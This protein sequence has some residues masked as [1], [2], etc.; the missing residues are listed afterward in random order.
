MQTSL[1]DLPFTNYGKAEL[2][3]SG[4]HSIPKSTP[5][6][7]PKTDLK[8]LT[9]WTSF[10]NDIH[11]AIQSATTRTN[12]PP[13]PF[14][15]KVSTTTRSVENEERIRTHATV[16]L[17]E[18]VEK[19]L[20]MLGV[21]G[22]FALPG[23]GN[24][25]I[26]GDPDFSWIMSPPQPHPRVIVRVPVTTCVTC[27]LLAV[28]PRWCRLSTKLGGRRI[29]SMLSLLLMALLVIPSANSPCTLS[30]KYTDI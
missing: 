3:P 29:W 8:T 27:C 22:W 4:T 19:V 9:P 25:A 7:Y 10:P 13:T 26:V 2:R 17:H 6:T 20:E 5:R 15:I 14:V 1:P 24:V 28:K 16:A 11:Q 30:N 21:N 12:L 18:A 23:G